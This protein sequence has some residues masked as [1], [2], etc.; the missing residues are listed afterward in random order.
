MPAI[1]DFDREAW[2]SADSFIQCIERSGAECRPTVA[3][4]RAWAAVRL[5]GYLRDGSP[6]SVLDRLP[7]SVKSVTDDEPARRALISEIASAEPT[8]HVANCQAQ[9]IRRLDDQGIGPLVEGALRRARSLGLLASHFGRELD[10]LPTIAAPMAASRVVEVFCGR[11]QRRFYL[12]LGLVEGGFQVVS[13]QDL[14]PDLKPR[15]RPTVILA[16][17]PPPDVVS[18]YI[19][20]PEE[21]L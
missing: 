6:V 16:L 21:Q 1:R 13:L 15:P 7:S 10:A 19:P 5:L 9:G 20:V 3:P 14:P 8:V 17:P 4:Y 2:A 11:T 12:V 18:P